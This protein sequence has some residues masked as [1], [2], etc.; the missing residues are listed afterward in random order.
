MGC[1]ESMIET[2]LL[3]IVLFMIALYFKENGGLKSV[4]YG[5]SEREVKQTDVKQDTVDDNLH[6]EDYVATFRTHTDDVLDNREFEAQNN[7]TED[8]LPDE[9]NTNTRVNKETPERRD[10]YSQTPEFSTDDFDD[11]DLTEDEYHETET[12]KEK[13]IEDTNK[14]LFESLRENN[15]NGDT[16]YEE[17][18]KKNQERLDRLRMAV[19]EAKAVQARNVDADEYDGEDFTY[20]NFF[21]DVDAAE[22]FKSFT[23]HARQLEE[24]V[25]SI[26]DVE[27]DTLSYDEM[28]RLL[29]LEDE[30]QATDEDEAEHNYQA[31][32]E[33]TREAYRNRGEDVLVGHLLDDEALDSLDRAEEYDDTSSHD[34][35]TESDNLEEETFGDLDVE[36]ND[37]PEV[38][39]ES[40]RTTAI[41]VR[42]LKTRFTRLEQTIENLKRKLEHIE[43]DALRTLISQQSNTAQRHIQLLIEAIE[44]YEAKYD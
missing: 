23:K 31:L 37:E 16:S 1:G 2:I 36:A 39:R 20:Q 15:I 40:Y 3:A 13:T 17:D 28:K 42:A 26:S 38:E 12:Y 4:Y 10:E 30:H 24:S 34:T 9:E 44:R 18:V 11:F 32:N 25:D 43:D 35:P 21:D 5:N 29:D 19:L 6:A 33:V 14:K 8:V 27:D 22:Q 7:Q 41:R